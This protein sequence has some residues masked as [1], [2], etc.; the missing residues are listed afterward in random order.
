MLNE[1]DV[2][3]HIKG[4]SD[5][6]QLTPRSFGISRKREQCIVKSFFPAS[7][8]DAVGFLKRSTGKAFGRFIHSTVACFSLKV[9]GSLERVD[10]TLFADTVIV[11]N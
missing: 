3:A 1:P 8:V 5:G 10:F 11:S 6:R 2:I 4:I 7:P 9:E